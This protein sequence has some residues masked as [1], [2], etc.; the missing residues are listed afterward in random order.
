[1]STPANNP[2][3]FTSQCQDYLDNRLP[4]KQKADFLAMVES[5]PEKKRLFLAYFALH[6]RLNELPAVAPSADFEARLLEAVS[7]QPCASSPL[8]VV[9]EKPKKKTKVVALSWFKKPKHQAAAAV[10]LAFLLGAGL[11]HTLWQEDPSAMMSPIAESSDQQLMTDMVAFWEDAEA[12]I[13]RPSFDPF[14][15]PELEAAVGL[16]DP[17]LDAMSMEGVDPYQPQGPPPDSYPQ[18][19]Y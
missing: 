9:G 3:D 14:S 16:E 17:A 1:M 8:V 19:G 10:L 15:S 18:P 11:K 4:P 13:S 7:S 6:G 5:N 2:D 12:D